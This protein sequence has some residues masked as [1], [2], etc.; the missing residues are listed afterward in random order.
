M[1]NIDSREKEI[2]MEYIEQYWEGCIS[3]DELLYIAKDMLGADA[4]AFLD[5]NASQY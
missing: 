4:K 5:A 2:V 3:W 1:H